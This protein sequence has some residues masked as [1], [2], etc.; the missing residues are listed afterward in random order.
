MCIY[1]RRAY[2][3]TCLR[4]EVSVIKPVKEDNADDENDDD[5]DYTRQIINDCTGSLA[6]IP[7]EP[8]IFPQKLCEKFL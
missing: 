4:C 1:V 7:N 5:D 8:K 2:A 6:F 3:H